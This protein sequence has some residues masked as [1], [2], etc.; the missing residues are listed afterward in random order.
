MMTKSTNIGPPFGLSRL[1]RSTCQPEKMAYAVQDRGLAISGGYIWS[2]LDGFQP[3]GIRAPFQLLVS[4]Y[5]ANYNE[6]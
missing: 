5:I 4:L 1:F 6:V 3:G 2:P